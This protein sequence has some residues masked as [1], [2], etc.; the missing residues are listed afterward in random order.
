MRYNIYLMQVSDHNCELS[1]QCGKVCGKSAESMFRGLSQTLFQTRTIAR[2]GLM[3]SASTLLPACQYGASC[4]RKN[5]DHFREF[6]HNTINN[7]SKKAKDQPTSKPQNTLTQPV[8]TQPVTQPIL[9]PTQT[10]SAPTDTSSNLNLFDLSNIDG[11]KPKV[12]LA[13]GDSKP[14]GEYTIT[15]SGDYYTCSCAG[16]KLS[17]LPVDVVHIS[18][19]LQAPPGYS[20]K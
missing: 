10:S 2:F 20:W 15:R 7:A 5:P 12:L 13:D 3:S 17:K 16:W 6:S 1:D 14:D 18:T 4:Y 11:V 9:P 19:N 8:L